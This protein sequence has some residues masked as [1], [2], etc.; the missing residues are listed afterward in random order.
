[1]SIKEWGK[2]PKFFSWGHINGGNNCTRQ[3]A[4]N[5]LQSVWKGPL[6]F[7]HAKFDLS[8][9][10]EKLGL[11]MPSWDRVHDTMFMLYLDDPRARSFQ[12]KPA[13]ERLLGMKPEERD[14]VSDWLC[15]H[16]PVPGRRLTP[17]KAVAFI[18]LAP[19]DIVGPYANGDT[20]RTE[21]IFKYGLEMLKNRSMR[22]AYDRERR[23]LPILLENERG[24]V[25]VDLDR[26]RNDVAA[27]NKLRINIDEWLKKQLKAKDINLNSADEL[28]EALIRSGKADPSKLGRTNNGKVSTNQES[29]KSGIKDPQLY[30]MLV[31]RSQLNTCLNTFMEP[32]LAVAERTG[33]MIHTSWNQVRDDKGGTTTGRFSSTPNFQNIPNEFDQLFWSKARPDLPKEP[34]PLLALPQVRSYVIPGKGRVLLDRDYSQQEVRILGHYE[35]ATLKAA[36]LK[37]PWMDA[38]DTTQEKLLDFGLD[39]ERKPVKNTN[40]GII[41]GQGAP[42]LAL[43]NDLSIE[44]SKRLMQAIKNNVFPGL[45]DLFDD[46]KQ[47]AKNDLPVRTWGGREYFCEE[48]MYSEKYGRWMT[49]DYKLLNLIIQGSAADCTK[50]ALIRWNDTKHEDDRFLLSVHDQQTID[51]PTKRRDDAMKRLKEAMESVE[52]DVPMLSEGKWSTTNWFELKDYDKRGK[53]LCR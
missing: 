27:Y 24:G 50:E 42:S 25:P 29:L 20:I 12:L 41:Y 28:S 10:T 43:K 17:S 13:G 1:V 36:Y 16:Q 4:T 5:A 37:D 2:K 11:P 9:A 3:D 22:E 7:H 30:A 18:A 38:H 14:A 52:F 23:L 51:T 48:P 19:G 8:V 39:Y 49:F 34:F 33:G 47:R 40:F 32:W 21:G 53:L 15:S 6:L 35:D 31:Y 46:L 44:D 45:K 26:L